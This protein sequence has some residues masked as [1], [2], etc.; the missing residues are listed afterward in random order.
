MADL[1]TISDETYGKAGDVIRAVSGQGPRPEIEVMPGFEQMVAGAALALSEGAPSAFWDTRPSH[2]ED[3]LKQG[4]EEWRHFHVAVAR[5]I[6]VH[7]QDHQTF[8]TPGDVMTHMV[9]DVMHQSVAKRMSLAIVNSDPV[10]LKALSPSSRDTVEY[11]RDDEGLAD[12]I[13]SEARGDYSQFDPESRREIANSLIN[14]ERV[15]AASQEAIQIAEK[16]INHHVEALPEIE[17]D[18]DSRLSDM[19]DFGAPLLLEVTEQ[20]WERASAIASGAKAPLTDVERGIVAHVGLEEH[21]EIRRKQTQ[22]IDMSS[23]IRASENMAA[24]ARA[25]AR[26]EEPLALPVNPS[27]QAA[28]IESDVMTTRIIQEN[29]MHDLHKDLGSQQTQGAGQR[30]LLAVAAGN[31][32]KADPKIQEEAF[33]AIRNLDNVAPLRQI[34]LAFAAAAVQRGDMVVG[35]MR[36]AR[37][38]EAKR[39]ITYEGDNIDDMR[40]QEDRWKDNVYLPGDM[41]RI[42]EKSSIIGFDKEDIRAQVGNEPVEISRSIVTGEERSNG[43]GGTYSSVLMQYEFKGVEGR[44]PSAQFQHERGDEHHYGAMMMKDERLWFVP[45]SD[46]L[47]NP[48]VTG[49]AREVTSTVGTRDGMKSLDEAKDFFRSDPAS[50]EFI[51]RPEAFGKETGPVEMVAAPWMSGLSDKE[52]VLVSKAIDEADR[53]K[54]VGQAKAAVIGA[55]MGRGAGI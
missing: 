1:G 14:G 32:E 16:A 42:N 19:R 11:A 15:T 17:R 41:V 31:F 53:T 45:M 21:D 8:D 48:A 6:D 34:D 26:S 27:I 35:I 51:V 25:L 54:D 47:D 22:T 36:E 7:S 5:V 46:D 4:S 28:R 33:T 23:D 24:Y 10:F 3:Y 44:F 20:H 49:F 37:E 29:A 13:R 9:A 30:D 39:T 18:R 40:K 12:L 55:A 50:G 43:L 2:A 52:A 38:N